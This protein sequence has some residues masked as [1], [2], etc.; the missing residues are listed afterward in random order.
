MSIMTSNYWLVPAGY[1]DPVPFE[2][3]NWRLMLALGLNLVAW[4]AFLMVVF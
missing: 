1:C 4:L 2:A 3:P